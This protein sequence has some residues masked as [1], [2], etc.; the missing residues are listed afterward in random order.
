MASEPDITSSLGDGWTGTLQN[1]SSGVLG[2]VGDFLG[3]SRAS[4]GDTCANSGV[5]DA[6]VFSAARLRTTLSMAAAAANTY[7][8]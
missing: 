6:G 3:V 1:L 4:N 8:A 7:T 2:S 5:T